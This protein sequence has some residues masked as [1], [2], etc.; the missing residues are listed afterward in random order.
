MPRIRTI[1][2]EFYDDAKLC[3][4]PVQARFL[5]IA[6]WVF[7]DDDGIV[8]GNAKW[9]KSKIFPYDDDLRVNS[10]ENWMLSLTK[11]QMLVPF[12]F[13]G[14]N[15][16]CI[17][18][19]KKHQRIDKP[20]PSLIPKDIIDKVVASF[21]EHSTN[22]PRTFQEHSSLE[23]EG[24]IEK[25]NGNFS[26]TEPQ[27][28]SALKVEEVIISTFLLTGKDN[29]EFQV[30]EKMVTEFTECYPAVD[31]EQELRNIKAWCISN[32]N[33]RK[34]KSGA[35]KFI[36]TWLADKQ[37]KS[38]G[39]NNGQQNRQ[40]KPPTT[41]ETLAPYAESWARKIEEQ[42]ARREMANSQ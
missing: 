12:T 7:A 35:M 6:L 20:Y 27:N 15:Y 41:I 37:N 19:F 36:N 40:H 18:T 9:L 2:P 10:I 29:P 30:T 11:A 38:K 16:Y 28:G 23:I 1:K 4:V 5:F 42:R 39:Q 21:D 34:T 3:E 13:K 24:E 33:K 31:V 8:R 32:P 22:I 17:R 14:E 25:G 26:C